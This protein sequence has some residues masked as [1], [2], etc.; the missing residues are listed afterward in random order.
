MAKMMKA[1]LQTVP[2]YFGERYN[3]GKSYIIMQ[4][5][6]YSVDEY[7]I[8]FQNVDGRLNLPQI[9]EHML[10]ALQSLHEINLVH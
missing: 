7:L 3:L 8:Q 1:G 2:K 4:L 9:C 5:V 10:R 6:E